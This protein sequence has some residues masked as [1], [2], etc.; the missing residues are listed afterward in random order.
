M[1]R[2]NTHATIVIISKRQH[3]FLRAF[4]WWRLAVVS[5]SAACRV[6]C[7]M[8]RTFPYMLSKLK[9]VNIHVQG[10][11]IYLI[12]YGCHFLARWQAYQDREI[13]HLA[14]WY[15]AQFPGSPLRVRKWAL[16]CILFHCPELEAVI[17]FGY[18]LVA[19]AVLLMLLL[20]LLLSAVTRILSTCYIAAIVSS[21]HTWDWSIAVVAFALST[22][23]LCLLAEIRCILWKSP[24]TFWKSL[25]SFCCSNFRCR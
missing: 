25:E 15:L 14:L 7:A 23:S 9:G 2:A 13:S 6:F 24:R 17:F 16:R 22:Y 1:I 10:V 3:I 5:S 18:R 4:F 8:L 12:T 19:V 20:F 21:T 11:P